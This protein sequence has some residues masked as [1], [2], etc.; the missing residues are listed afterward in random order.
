MSLT[1][2]WMETLHNRDDCPEFAHD[3]L[4]IIH[5]GLLHPHKKKRWDCSKVVAELDRIRQKCESSKEY[6]LAPHKWTRGS[7]EVFKVSV[8]ASPFSYS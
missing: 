3:V 2:Q 5:R 7:L 8:N 6:C 1:Q 4:S